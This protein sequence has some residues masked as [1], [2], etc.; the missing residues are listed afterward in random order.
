MKE[1][2]EIASTIVY[3]YTNRDPSFCSI[4]IGILGIVLMVLFRFHHV[5]SLT[6]TPNPFPFQHPFAKPILHFHK[7]SLILVTLGVLEP[8][9]VAKVMRH[10]PRP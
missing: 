4:S 2:L 8:F 3:I 10:D 6:K 7:E 1:E 5:K 9:L